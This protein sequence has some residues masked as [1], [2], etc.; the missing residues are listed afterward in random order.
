MPS[1]PGRGGNSQR[2][3]GDLAAEGADVDA[4]S[5][6]GG[7]GQ[8]VARA[9][10]ILPLERAITGAQSREGAIDA[11][12]IDVATAEGAGR[13]VDDGTG[14]CLPQLAAVGRVEAEDAAG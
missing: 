12:D 2:Q 14:R 4:A 3:R 11:A 10:V 6:G 5:V 8:H 1:S 13:V 7:R 9:K